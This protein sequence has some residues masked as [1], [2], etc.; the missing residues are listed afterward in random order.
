MITA[1]FRIK[2]KESL[3]ETFNYT[4]GVKKILA[5]LDSTNRDGNPWSS[6]SIRNVFNGQRS[7]RA[8]ETAIVELYKREIQIKCKLESL[9]SSLKNDELTDPEQDQNR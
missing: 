7:N 9:R 2:F 1:K 4:P 3:G 5:E 6:Q 8:I